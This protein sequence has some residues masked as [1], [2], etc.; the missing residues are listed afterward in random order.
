[1]KCHIIFFMAIYA[2]CAA[3]STKKWEIFSTFLTLRGKT[4]AE[5]RFFA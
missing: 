1:M 4:P 2:F 5:A 3:F